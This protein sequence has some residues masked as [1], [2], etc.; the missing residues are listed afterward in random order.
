MEHEHTH[1]QGGGHGEGPT[2]T[3]TI[4]GTGIEVHA[5]ELS[6]EQLVELAYP[7]GTVPPKDYVVS[8]GRRGDSGMQSMLPGQ[9]I[10]LKQGMIFDVE[11]A[12]RS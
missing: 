3:I 6:F 12:N 4:N 9:V 1:E 11:P 5:K 8:W 2:R 7:D 10:K